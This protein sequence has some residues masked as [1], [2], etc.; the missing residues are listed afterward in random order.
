[1][2]VH[3]VLFTFFLILFVF[4]VDNNLPVSQLAIQPAIALTHVKAANKYMHSFAWVG[5][6]NWLYQKA[7]AVASVKPQIRI[8]FFLDFNFMRTEKK[9]LECYCI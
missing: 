9:Q 8:E 6:E 7:A 4:V 3:S 5:V 2:C 1:M